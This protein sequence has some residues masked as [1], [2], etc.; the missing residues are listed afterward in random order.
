MRFDA[1]IWDLHDDPDGNVQHCAEHGVTQEEIEEV[2]EN[3]CDEDVSTSSGRPVVFGDTRAG[4]HLM[5]VYDRID[6]DTVYPV[7]AY[8]VPRR[9]RS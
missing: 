4:R 7:T 6:D 2:F 8:E 1:I 3:V 9:Q 5:V